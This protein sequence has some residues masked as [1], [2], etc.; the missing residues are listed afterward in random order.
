LYNCVC[1]VIFPP[2]PDCNCDV[3]HS[4]VVVLKWSSRRKGFAVLLTLLHVMQLRWIQV[5]AHSMV[6]WL[7]RNHVEHVAVVVCL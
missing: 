1:V 7:V 4:L 6:L 3:V 5:L 2:D